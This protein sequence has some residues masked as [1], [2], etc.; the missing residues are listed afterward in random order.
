MTIQWF[1]LSS[2]KITGKDVTIITDPFGKESGL[3]A[4]RGNADIIICSDPQNPW[5]NNFSSISG[6]P[7]TING[8]GEYDI[9]G[10]FV[11][12]AQ[13]EAKNNPQAAIYCIEIE[14]I[15]I[16]FLGPIKISELNDTQKQI[17]EGA[18][19]VLV[20]VGGKQ[21]MTAEEAA[22]ISTKLEPF[23]IVPHTYKSTGVSVDLDKVDKFLKE[24]GGKNTEMEKLTL[25]KKELTG[26]STSLVVLNPMRWSLI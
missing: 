6:T 11:M 2:F 23:Y 15:R 16:A 12:G 24:L 26:E 10:V 17:L 19:I 7:F 18:D 1:G 8:P 14:D 21:V 5:C 20:P 25:K 3:S 22:K 4:V 13:A 9:K